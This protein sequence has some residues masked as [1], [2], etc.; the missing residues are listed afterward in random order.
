M[1]GRGPLRLSHVLVVA[2]LT[3]VFVWA[4]FVT[5]PSAAFASAGDG[6]TAA[7]LAPHSVT[8]EAN[9]A[10]VQTTS[11]AATVGDFL[12]ERNLSVGP[13]DYV[14]PDQDVP[15]SDGLAVTYRAAVS[16][17]IETAHDRVAVTSSAD[18]VGSLLEEENIRLDAGD[19]VQPPLDAAL[20]ANGV[21]R[22][23][24]V[25]AWQRTERSAIEPQT[26]HRLDFSITPGSSRVL[27]R[28]SRGERE[29]VVRFERLDGGPVTRTVVSSHVLRKARPQIVADGI[30]EYEAFARMEQRGVE[31]T[32]YLAESALQMVAT[33]YTAGCY[34]CSGITA[35]GRPA[36]H[37]IVAVDPSVIPLGT[38]LFI[39]GYG[40]AIA[41]D[42]GGA[43]RGLRI[44]LGFN[45]E[46]D[47]LLFGRR[48]VTV[49]RLK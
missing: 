36:G 41:G 43:I 21:V 45:S 1:I 22:I 2:L 28:G 8:L 16:V 35:I 32:A 19:R 40:L 25:V 10:P 14:Y 13:H 29:D 34:G 12:R 5:H 24:H 44:D 47:A 39:P 4:G 6:A 20:P 17:T 18:D 37:G 3:A 9:G 42:T 26:I 31:R 38:R 49:Y 15:L 48:E 30:D 7:P 46:R 11:D 27:A 33:A 23:V